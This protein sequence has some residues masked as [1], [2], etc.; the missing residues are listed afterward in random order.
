MPLGR[1]PILI[2]NR[3]TA[4]SSGEIFVCRHPTAPRFGHRNDLDAGR[5]RCKT[6]STRDSLFGA[7]VADLQLQWSTKSQHA[8]RNGVL[9]PFKLPA[10]G[11]RF[12][13]EPPSECPSETRQTKVRSWPGS[14][15]FNGHTLLQRR[16][17]PNAQLGSWLDDAKSQCR[18]VALGK[19]P[20]MGSQEN[21]AASK[22]NRIS[23][24]MT[25]CGP[26]T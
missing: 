12:Q 15:S 2:R 11:Q 19:K 4:S 3:W 20:F 25:G 22:L 21:A 14:T 18:L 5:P 26:I 9:R 24:K 1:L 8:K 23:P 6:V 16:T 7:D 13:T 10:R 17:L